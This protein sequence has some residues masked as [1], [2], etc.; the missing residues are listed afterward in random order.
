M[1][2]STGSI[3]SPATRRGNIADAFISSSGFIGKSSAAHHGLIAANLQ[4]LTSASI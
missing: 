1:R 2:R 3:V 4:V